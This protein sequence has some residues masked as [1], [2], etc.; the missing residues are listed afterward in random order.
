MN[1]QAAVCFL[2]VVTL[3]TL[4]TETRRDRVRAVVVLTTP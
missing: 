1:P 3:Q 4:N 2:A